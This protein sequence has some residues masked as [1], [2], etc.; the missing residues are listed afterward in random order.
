MGRPVDSRPPTVLMT[1]SI[2]WPEG[3]NQPPPWLPMPAWVYWGGRTMFVHL[4]KECGAGP[5]GKGSF[6]S[7]I[8]CRPKYLD[9]NRVQLCKRCTEEYWK[10]IGT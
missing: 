6:K 7:M 1:A 10:R 2:K 3:R 4:D 5:A 8:G 9:W